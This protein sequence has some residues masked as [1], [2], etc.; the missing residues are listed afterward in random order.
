[1]VSR[2]FKMTSFSP[3]CHNWLARSCF[4]ACYSACANNSV[5]ELFSRC[6]KFSV[7]QS[8]TKNICKTFHGKILNGSQ[9]I[10]VHMSEKAL[11]YPEIFPAERDMM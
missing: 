2:D 5:F 7:S 1:M 6:E 8:N 9:E 3:C 11:K 10:A 4:C